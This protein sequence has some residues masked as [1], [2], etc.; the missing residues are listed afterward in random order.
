MLTPKEALSKY[1]G[2]NSF[3]HSQQE[4]IE[5]II[6]GDN[7]LA[8]LP[9]GAGKSICYQIP[10][11]I[12]NDF[13]IVVSPLI[14]LMKDQVDSLNKNGTAAAFINSQMSF[15][16]AE[17]VLKR[18]S[19][20][21]IKLLFV[22]PERLDNILF[23]DKIKNLN[24]Y[25]LFVDEAHCISEWGHSFRPSYRKIKE[26]VDYVSIKKVSGFTATA[27]PEVVKDIIE[28]LG[29]QNPNIFVKGFERENLELNV[30]VTKRKKEKCLELISRHKSPAIIYTA[31]RKRAEEISEFLNLHRLNCAYYHAGLAPEERKK[32]QEDFMLGN[33]P[34][35]AATNAFGMGIDKKDI[36]LVI[37]YNT[38]GSIENYYQEIGRAGRDGKNSFIYLL[39]DEYDINIQNF[40]LSNSHPD[41]ELIQKI[42]DAICDYGKVAEGNISKSEIPLNINFISTCAKREISKGLL[43]SSLKILEQ[44]GYLKQPSE[45]ENKSSIQILFEKNKLKDFIKNNSKDLIKEIVLYLLREYGSKI[46]I[47]KINISSKQISEIT[48]YVETDI[49]EILLTL[50]NLGI[51]KYLKPRTKESVILTSPRV[52]SSRLRLDYKKINENYL[53]LRKKI[54]LMEDY[55]YTS[56][57]RFKYILKYF[58]EAVENYSCGKC[59]RCKLEENLP[60]STNEYI[61]EIILRTLN[62]NKFQLNENSLITVIRG[63]SKTEKYKSFETYGCCGNYEKEILKSSFHD[64]LLTGFM[65]RND[66]NF[67]YITDSGIE[68]LQEKGLIFEDK[69]EPINFETNL[70]L[71][72]LLREARAKAANKFMQTG[73]L[74]CPDEV[75][76]EISDK[77]PKEKYELLSIKGFNHRMFNKIGDD[78]LEIVREFIKEKDKKPKE[79]IED[80]TIPQNIK[81]TLNL[82]SK[83]YSLK[84]ISSLRQLSE[85]VVSMQIET[86]LEYEPATEIKHLF[87]PDLFDQIIK[88]IK[89]GYK[90]LKELKQRLPDEIT[91]PLIRIAVAKFNSLKH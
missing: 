39:H 40:F 46:F 14:A 59:D 10:A 13:S 4:I 64:I 19:F 73:Y 20:G 5:A 75:L 83:K 90:D 25:Y 27:T 58:G 23:A 30:I 38:P 33:I 34:I 2:Y 62:E 42:Y 36:R 55:V 7:V 32:I 6:N 22:A 49:E 51:I 21:E 78:F 80:R 16:E 82:L 26:F 31:S 44:G 45:F 17:E 72:N 77:M 81:E 85:A 8:V 3:R 68:F 87:K 52:N 74:I 48:G 71:F 65:G 69:P 53:H 1:F 79:K 35:I 67:L 29:F 60:E 9:T 57:C 86:I 84:D 61:K 63:S 50:D 18:I 37:H 43:Y 88:E 56:E 76:R 47:D 89:I 11:L 41:K 24:P 54:E 70:E 15:Y 12:S 91:Y 28:Q 66:N